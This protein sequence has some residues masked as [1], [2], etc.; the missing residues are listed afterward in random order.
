MCMR[1]SEGHRLLGMASGCPLPP[2]VQDRPGHI[3]GKA[4]GVSDTPTLGFWAFQVPGSSHRGESAGQGLC[5]Q[6]HPCPH[7]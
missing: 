7:G 5:S 4:E 6:S 1:V 3:W 2:R